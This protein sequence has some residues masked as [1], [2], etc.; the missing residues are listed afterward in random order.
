MPIAKGMRPC[1]L[2]QPSFEWRKH[3]HYPEDEI[4]A[5]GN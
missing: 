4:V 3:D 2:S 1:N 5:L